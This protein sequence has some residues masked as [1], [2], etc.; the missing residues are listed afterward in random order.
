MKVNTK[1]FVVGMP[2]GLYAELE[3]LAE[4]KRLTVPGYIRRVLWRHVEELEGVLS[5]LS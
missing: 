2:P 3:K 4:K 5:R 1:K